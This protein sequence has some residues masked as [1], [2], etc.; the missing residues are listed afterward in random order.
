MQRY[1][2]EINIYDKKAKDVSHLS[3]LQL[4]FI[5]PKWQLISLEI[6]HIFVVEF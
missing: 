1:L 2:T 4:K 6:L 5:G 3:L